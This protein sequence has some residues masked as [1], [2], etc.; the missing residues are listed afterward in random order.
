MMTHLSLKESRKDCNSGLHI[1]LMLEPQ[2]DSSKIEKRGVE[3]GSFCA[4]C[5]LRLSSSFWKSKPLFCHY[6][7]RWFCEG[8]FGRS[9]QLCT[10]PSV[11]IHQ[12][13]VTKKPVCQLVYQYLNSIRSHPLVCA[14]SVNPNLYTKDSAL[15]IARKL[16]LQI[17]LAKEH[18]SCKSR[19]REIITI[20]D[21][22]RMYLCQDTEMYSLEDLE[23]ACNGIL[24]PLLREGY[25]QVLRHI[26]Q[27]TLCCG[28]GYICEL[29]NSDT[30][31]YP[32]QIDDVVECRGCQTCFHRKC[33]LVKQG[34][35]PRCW[36]KQNRKTLL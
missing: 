1:P 25:A 32:F 4:G 29:C 26:K 24:V 11:L 16:R 2:A 12:W 35:C 8:C 30:P 28:R 27:C 20:L 9:D 14:S 17:V 13:K 23:D 7:Q 19:F 18:V 22:E 33:Y 36:R 21:G 5:D 6:L 3:T 31:I 34:T 15:A 10:I